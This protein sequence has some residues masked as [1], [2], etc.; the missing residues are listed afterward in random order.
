M[1]E[2]RVVSAIES[3]KL[4][5]NGLPRPPPLP[6]TGTDLLSL[7]MGTAPVQLLLDNA[8]RAYL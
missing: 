7:L 5:G 4:K 8:Q 1:G 6:C 3:A 2:V